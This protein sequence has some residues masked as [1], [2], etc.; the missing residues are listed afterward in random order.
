MNMAGILRMVA[1]MAASAVVSS[2]FSGCDHKELCMEHPHIPSLI[3]RFDWSY[4][5][6]ANPGGMAVFFYEQTAERSENDGE[7]PVS[8]GIPRRHDL[9]PFE[10]SK[11]SLPAGTY[12]IIAYNNDT[13][14]VLF[15]DENIFT[16]H[17]AYTREAGVFEPVYGSSDNST[18]PKG[19][20]DK[21]DGGDDAFQ[22]VLDPN[23]MWAACEMDVEVRDNADGDQ[24]ITLYPKP[25]T[26]HYTV[27]WINVGRLS[28][29]GVASA[30]LDGLAREYEFAS[31]RLSDPLVM[32]PFGV[33]KDGKDS[34]KGDFHTFGH[35]PGNG[36][37]SHYVRLYCWLNDGRQVYFDFDVTDQ[38]KESPDPRNVSI[39]IDGL[40]LPE[41]DTGDGGSFRVDVDD[42]NEIYIDLE[43]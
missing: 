33:T 15:R 3:V 25:I 28:S 18:P 42:F 14:G 11:V 10:D 9:H 17:T 43:M 7:L 30:T 27:R 12:H 32:I 29:L 31:G 36:H 39:V 6:E 16:F 23:Q 8:P 19:S 4:S 1:V 35:N 40:K 13:D 34:L 22:S 26:C 37:D 5:P 20:R 38:V 21:D 41:V 2:L 24:I